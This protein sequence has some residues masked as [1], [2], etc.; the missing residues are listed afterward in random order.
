MRPGTSVG[1]T[2]E[3]GRRDD[4][5]ELAALQSAW[6][7]LLQAE[8]ALDNI[9]SW[10][11]YLGEL[12][13]QIKTVA[14]EVELARKMTIAL[15]DG[16]SRPP[17]APGPVIGQPTPAQAKSWQQH[18]ELE[19]IRNV[20]RVRDEVV[21]RRFS[22]HEPARWTVTPTDAEGMFTARR[23]DGLMIGG[24]AEAPET[25]PD[26]LRTWSVPF[27]APVVIDWTEPP[28][29]PVGRHELI[30]W[31]A[32]LKDEAL[33][34]A[35][36]PERLAAFADALDRLR[37]SWPGGDLEGRLADSAV[38]LNVE[39]PQAPALSSLAEAGRSRVALGWI[40][41]AEWV[42]AVN[43]ACTGTPQWNGFG[44]H[45]PG[46][47]KWIASALLGDG[48]PEDVA[49]LWA[50][51]S[52][53]VHLMRVPGPAGPLYQIASNGQHRMHTARLL[54]APRLWAVVEQCTLLTEVRW[55]DLL[56]YGSEEGMKDLREI[57]LGTWRGGLARGLIEGE[58][59]EER[60][61]L[62]PVWV[63]APWVL[64][65]PAIA[66]AWARNYERA[67]PG[68]LGAFGVPSE[69]WRSGS[70]WSEWITG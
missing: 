2:S 9:E 13:R 19:H 10:T 68:A 32:R 61:M 62:Y 11:L 7:L 45:R 8:N 1:N 66:A 63:L 51:P 31:P 37:R 43:V 15:H 41:A 5:D 18:Y 49:E 50:T 14:A 36:A 27:G 29:Q 16:L 40:R 55:D 20:A 22:D 59:D 39:E 33:W 52:N 53:P 3:P 12:R 26:T 17:G 25:V 70:H 67:Y 48:S 4:E 69:A 65:W 56:G 6:Q 58:L 47:V 42:D 60:G 21:A 30:S 28:P 54:G 23:A 57:I 35:E 38:R 46:Q 44:H 24:W 64:A 34:N